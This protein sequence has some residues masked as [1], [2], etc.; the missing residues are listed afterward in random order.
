MDKKIDNIIKNLWE[1]PDIEF[2]VAN[3]VGQKITDSPSPMDTA[4][5]Y[6]G[7]IAETYGYNIIT[8]KLLK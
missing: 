5:F 6:G 7:E 4:E 3:Y 1:T 2:D 8:G